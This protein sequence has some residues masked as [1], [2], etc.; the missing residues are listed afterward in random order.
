MGSSHWSTDAYTEATR[1]RKAAGKSSFA[2]SDC[3][4]ASGRWDIH[5]TL[6]PKSVTFR[7][8]RDSDAHPR[9]NAI[10]VLFDETGSMGGI[11]LVFQQKLGELMKVLLLKGYIQ[12]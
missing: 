10:A 9:S 2:Y 12:D 11:P 7:E 4:R 3:A 8:S 1:L 5:P 6:D